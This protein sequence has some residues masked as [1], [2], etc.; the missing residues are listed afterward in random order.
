MSA[1]MSPTPSP[2]C[3]KEVNM[4]KAFSALAALSILATMFVGLMP[5]D[6][7]A[8]T[9]T[10]PTAEQTLLRKCDN[11]VPQFVLG[12]IYPLKGMPTVD[13]WIASL[14]YTMLSAAPSRSK[15]TAAKMWWYARSW[16]G[17]L[18]VDKTGG[19][20]PGL[21][22]QFIDPNSCRI[23]TNGVSKVKELVSMLRAYNGADRMSACQVGRTEK[24]RNS[25]AAW[26]RAHQGKSGIIKGDLRATCGKYW[27]NTD[28]KLQER[29]RKDLWRCNNLAVTWSVQYFTPV[30][31]D[32]DVV[33]V[34]INEKGETV[35]MVVNGKT[36]TIKSGQTCPPPPARYICPDGR[37]VVFDITKC[38][39]PP[40]TTNGTIPPQVTGPGA[41][42]TTVA[43]PC[44]TW[45]N[46]FVPPKNPDGTCP[47]DPATD[48]LVN[49]SVPAAVQGPS[50]GG[51]PGTNCGE[52][53]AAGYRP[54]E[55]TTTMAPRAP[56]TTAAPATTAPPATQPPTTP[57]PTTSA[58]PVCIWG[59]G[60]TP[61]T[62]PPAGR[63]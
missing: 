6:A 62:A 53:N 9:A 55:T 34:T 31:I 27:F 43:P 36:V 35:P 39:P 63:V 21:P 52:P 1:I 58:P 16:T 29:T 60:G 2:T 50:G 42:T 19:F 7:D 48:P 51:Q 30:K 25:W 11:G 14:E 57:V 40:A 33:C 54:C 26:G 46:G 10:L 3:R 28:G 20:D 38:P 44:P 32:L 59:C 4:R 12:G 24:L 47:K 15:T 18:N 5:S 17:L 8:Q 37:T 61:T 49:T 41:T 23:S 56:T 13:G 22:S 45:K